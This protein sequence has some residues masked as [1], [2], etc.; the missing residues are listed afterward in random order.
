[1][2]ED[3]ESFRQWK[4]G[5]AIYMLLLSFICFVNFFLL[6]GNYYIIK[7]IYLDDLSELGTLWWL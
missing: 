2:Q 4:L 6:E 1:M 7:M 5:K 3:M